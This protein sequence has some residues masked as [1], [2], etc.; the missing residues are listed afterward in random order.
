VSR[1]QPND[2]PRLGPTLLAAFG[3]LNL[4]PLVNLGFCPPEPC[5]RFITYYGMD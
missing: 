5:Y 1:A 4:I 2:L 3:E